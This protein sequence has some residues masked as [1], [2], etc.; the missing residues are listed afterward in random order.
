M[1]N[2]RRPERQ[3][4]LQVVQGAG[5]VLA[6][7]RVHQVEIEIVDAGAAQFGHGALDVARHVDAPQG[8]EPG[9]VETLRA[10][11]HAIDS[12]GRVLGEATVLDRAGVRLERDLRVGG[13]RQHAA[14]V[15]QHLADRSR[16][17]QAGRAAAKEHGHDL[18]TARLV[19][20]KLEVTL[21]RRD[22]WLLGDAR[23]GH[24]V[25]IEIA[26]RAL[27]HAPGQ[28]HVQRQRNAG[29]VDHGAPAA[30]AATSP[31][32]ACPR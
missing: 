24:G 26:V 25:R 27:A 13:E 23:R 20:G 16:R 19:R 3:C 29:R 11:R 4:A 10:E 17:E 2:V 30:S 5:Q 22:V 28:V 15:R 12:L 1:R 8:G 31:R 14:C 18:A 6:R 32:K 9:I 21:Q 7:Q